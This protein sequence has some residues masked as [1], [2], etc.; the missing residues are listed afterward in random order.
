MSS[1]W[2]SFR[3]KIMFYSLLSLILALCTDFLLIAGFFGIWNLAHSVDEDT[4]TPQSVIDYA[5]E[6]NLIN[7]NDR[8]DNDKK[9]E[10]EEIHD[11]SDEDLVN[12]PTTAS[13]KAR[14]FL[15]RYR[16]YKQFFFVMIILAILIGISMFLF[17][18]QMFTRKMS[19]Y[20]TEIS[21]GI[22]GIATGG[23]HKTVRVTGEDEFANIAEKL[24]AMAME[25]RILIDNE[26]EYE[27]E[28]SDLIT[29]VAHDLRTPLASIIG[30]LDLVKRKENLSEENRMKYI[31]IAY[32]KSK[33]LETLINDL[34]EFT[35]VGAAKIKKE[36]TEL[37]FRKFMEQMIE[38][39][40]PSFED[41]DLKCVFSEDVECGMIEADGELLARGIE[42]LFSNAVKYG[43]DG[44]IIKV[45]LQENIQENKMHL[46]ITNFGEII[47]EEDLEHVFDKF[48]RVEGSRSV[49]TGGTGLG[50]AIAKK[51]I[52]LHNGQIQVTSDY[53]GTV[54]SI[55][56]PIQRVKE[57]TVEVLE[58]A[59]DQI[60]QSE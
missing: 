39:F 48:F 40:Y 9:E 33:R 29:N 13:D 5:L 60:K 2:K 17:Y 34:F 49:E 23:F 57:S 10:Q 43:K 18:F 26:R 20:L 21:D 51:V 31:S 50:L 45:H 35:K 46:S 8:L 36:F 25:I 14:S 6:E 19:D 53:N 38:E 3:F 24:N 4:P 47:S 56:L 42:N 52:L 30:Y 1:L 12:D 16:K 41:A 11:Y 37:D 7:S 58:Q 28:K 44:K 15:W 32:D 59:I 27:K 54:F 55:T 22:D